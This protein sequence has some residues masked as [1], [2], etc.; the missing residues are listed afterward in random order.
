MIRRSRTRSRLPSGYYKFDLNFSD[1]ACPSG[2]SYIVGVTAPTAAYIAGYSQI[3][4][5]TS[6]ASTAPFSVPAC[7][8]SDR[9]RRSSRPRR[10][11]KC[12]LPNSR[13]LR[14]C[15]RAAA[16]TVYHAHCRSTTS[17]VPGSS[18]DLQQPHP[19]RSGLER[20]AS[21]S[22]RRRR[23]AQRDA[24]PDGAVHDHG[25]QHVRRAA[26][27]L[28]ARR[29][30]PGRLPLR[31][32]LGA[33]RRRGGRADDGRARVHLER[34]RHRCVGP[35]HVAAAARRR[36]RRLRGRVRESRAGDAAG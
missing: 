7:P 11:A 27:R 9:R 36:R 6:D 18:A 23:L 3:I 30:L 34:P 22:R 28:A 21:R 31:R 15:P 1:P 19:A 5:P 17:D 29:P 10:I 14:R 35:A 26:R 33:Y 16:G 4:P 24:R 25:Q 32:G 8:G 20:C 13:L 2:G 12:R